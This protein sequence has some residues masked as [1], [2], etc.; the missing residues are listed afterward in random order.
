MRYLQENRKLTVQDH[1]ENLYM[2][3]IFI[4]SVH[5]HKQHFYHY[6]L[7]TYV[8]REVLSVVQEPPSPLVEAWVSPEHVLFQHHTAEQWNQPHHGQDL[9]WHRLL[10]VH[11]DVVVEEPILLIPQT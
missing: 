11:S 8:M 6:S 9:K 5:M 3:Y 2:T 10:T 1:S 4:I 7:Y